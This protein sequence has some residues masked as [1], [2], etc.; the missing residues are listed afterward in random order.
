M[1]VLILRFAHGAV[2][3][4]SLIREAKIIDILQDFNRLITK[5]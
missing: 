4:Y 1:E 5:P 2:M 3:A